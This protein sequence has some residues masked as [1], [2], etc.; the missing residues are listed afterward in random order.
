MGR[1]VNKMTQEH[2]QNLFVINSLLD[3]IKDQLDQRIV[4]NHK[5]IED[6]RQQIAAEIECHKHFCHPQPKMIQAP[7]DGT[8]LESGATIAQGQ[9]KQRRSDYQ[10]LLLD[11][12]LEFVRKEAGNS[13]KGLYSHE[14]LQS[15]R[16]FF[17][18][19]SLFQNVCVPRK[20]LTEDLVNEFEPMD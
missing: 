5:T 12:F 4:N 11:I 8:R 6:L 17:I 19:P 18:F 2:D 9:V 14:R 15:I 13:K 16:L 20:F 1:L 3:Q 10:R 7:W